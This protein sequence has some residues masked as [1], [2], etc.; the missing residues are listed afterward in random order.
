MIRNPRIAFNLLFGAG[1]DNADR[2]SRR[3]HQSILDWI[4]AKSPAQAELGR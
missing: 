4:T 3:R 2:I 1:T